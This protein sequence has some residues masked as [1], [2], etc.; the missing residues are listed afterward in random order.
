MTSVVF[1]V[2]LIPAGGCVTA[3]AGAVAYRVH[4]ALSLCLSVCVCVCVCVCVHRQPAE[5]VGSGDKQTSLKGALSAPA[6][7]EL[8]HFQIRAREGVQMCD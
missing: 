8:F 6:A 4:R 1:A 7:A 3:L 5:L 2:N